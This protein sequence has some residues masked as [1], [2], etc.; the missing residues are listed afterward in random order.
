MFW[1]GIGRMAYTWQETEYTALSAFTQKAR[2][3][4]EDWFDAIEA[5]TVQERKPDPF[6]SPVI[7]QEVADGVVER[8]D[9]EF[10]K[11]VRG[12]AS[13]ESAGSYDAGPGFSRLEPEQRVAFCQALSRLKHEL[14]VGEGSY[15]DVVP[16]VG[17]PS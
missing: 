2:W 7:S 4:L 1:M 5:G 12:W 13:S 9:Q 16:G 6:Y 11:E 17:Y 15:P 3:L 8:I 14:K 10:D